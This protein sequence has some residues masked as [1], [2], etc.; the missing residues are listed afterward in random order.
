MGLGL[1]DGKSMD[2]SQPGVCMQAQALRCVS[3]HDHRHSARLPAQFRR[4]QRH[5]GRSGPFFQME[6]CHPV[7]LSSLWLDVCHL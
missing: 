6:P 1:L 7:K 4:V 3:I 2:I 5:A